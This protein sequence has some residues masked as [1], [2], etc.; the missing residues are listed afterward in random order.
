M[1]KPN[2]ADFT[3]YA[4][5]KRAYD[6]WRGKNPERMAANRER[7]AVN[8]EAVLEQKKT[9]FQENKAKIRNYQRG[10]VKDRYHADSEFR[11]KSIARARAS[12]IANWEHVKARNSERYHSSPDL[13]EKVKQ[14]N[15]DYMAGNADKVAEQRTKFREEN[16]ALLAEHS[17]QWRRGK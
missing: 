6:R 10:Y 11:A 16:R 15:A 7:Y 9:Y 12:T 17:R 1:D 5:Y 8:R 4:E 2:R 3:E 13:Q 14:R